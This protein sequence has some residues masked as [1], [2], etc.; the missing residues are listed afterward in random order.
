MPTLH[1][2]GDLASG[3]GWR[4][5]EREV[6]TSGPN[7]GQAARVCVLFV[8]ASEKEALALVKVHAS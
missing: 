3:G 5:R 1:C 2:V 6:R 7:M 4:R 8:A